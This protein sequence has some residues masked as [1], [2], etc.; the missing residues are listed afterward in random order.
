MEIRLLLDTY[1]FRAMF[2]PELLIM[3]IIACV[4]YLR[5]SG[6]EVDNKGKTSFVFGLLCSYV[7]LGGPLNLMGHFWF[8]I[9]MLQ[10]SVLYLVVPPLLYRGLSPKVFLWL[11]E[12]KMSRQIIR[13][14][15]HPVLALFVFN[16]A[17]SFYHI[18]I[19]FDAAMSN[20]ALHN[21]LHILLFASAF[22]LWWSVFCPSGSVN[23]MSDLKK[24]AYIFLNGFMLTPACALIIFSDKLLYEIYTGA[25]HL[26][27]LP[28]YSLTVDKPDISISWLTPIT[29]QQAGGVVMKIVQE[30]AYGTILG[31]VFFQWYK[32]EKEEAEDPEDPLLV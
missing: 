2:S 25:T 29:D 13:I 3:M 5:Y 1:G 11:T 12:K 31:Y 17:F 15:A 19:I 10:Q 7:A 22:C 28:F 8:S 30:I 6:R 24:M 20:Y 4:F 16:G 23:A 9:H 14:A 27:C 26:L 32:K 18:P 21:S